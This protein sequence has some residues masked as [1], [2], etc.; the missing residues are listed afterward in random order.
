MKKWM[1]IAILILIIILLSCQKQNTEE[2]A[3]LEKAKGKE[4]SYPIAAEIG[5]NLLTVLDQLDRGSVD[6]GAALLLD[7]V[8][9]TRPN[10]NMPQEFENKILASKFKFQQ[11]NYA[12]AV[13]LI[14]EALLIFKTCAD[15]PGEK[16]K[17]ERTDIEQ[18]Q[19]KEESSQIA[20]IAELMRSKILSAI[21]EFKKGNADKGVIFILES[22]QLFGPKTD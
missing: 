15:L 19:K 9:L 1:L 10:E 18:T 8:L 17:E 7:A 21:D 12:E 11:R 20:P 5:S 3:V 14:T 13:E 6:K 16:D 2:P 22:L 4:E